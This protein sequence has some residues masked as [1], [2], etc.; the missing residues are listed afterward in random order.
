MDPIVW[1]NAVGNYCHLKRGSRRCADRPAK[2]FDEIIRLK[3]P[4]EE[5]EGGGQERMV[6]AEAALCRLLER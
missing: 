2:Y 6:N 3:R 5:V 1:N 4:Y